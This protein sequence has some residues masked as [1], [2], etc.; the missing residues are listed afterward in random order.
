MDA[1]LVLNADWQPLHRVRLKHALRM[2]WRA[3]AEVHEA[4]PDQMIGIWPRPRVVRLVKYVVT[5]WRHHRGPVWS[6]PG[7]LARDRRRCGYCDAPAATIDHIVPRSRGGENTWVNKV[8]A[9]GGCNQR[10]ANRTPAEAGMV[11]RVAP[12]AP[13]W[14]SAGVR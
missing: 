12:H 7:V 5:R 10:K 2:L 4:D 13:T 9:C 1:V 14:A 8:A 11:L 3:V 6:R